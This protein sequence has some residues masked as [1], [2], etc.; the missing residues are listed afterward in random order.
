MTLWKCI[1]K[2]FRQEE[3]L[4]C[5]GIIRIIRK[6]AKRFGATV[7]FVMDRNNNVKKSR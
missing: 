6:N 4:I 2:K 3:A 1:I 7:S 5:S